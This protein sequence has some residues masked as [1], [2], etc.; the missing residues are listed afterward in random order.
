ME[1]QRRFVAGGTRRPQRGTGATEYP[2]LHAALQH[3]QT[4]DPPDAPETWQ[5]P[6]PDPRTV[7]R[8]AQAAR[9]ILL[10]RDTG[11][12]QSIA[13]IA[14]GAGVQLVQ[15]RETE[16]TRTHQRETVLVGH[17]CAGEAASLFPGARLV[18]AGFEE[19]QDVLWRAAARSPG[20]RVAVLPQASAWLGEYLGELGLNGGAARIT[21]LAGGCGGAGTSTLAALLAATHTLAG[22]RTLLID[23]D[24]VSTGLWPMLRPREPEGIGWEDL[25]HSRGALAPGQ[26]AEILPLAQGSAVLSWVRQPGSY[27]PEESLVVAVLAASRRIYEDIVIDA[28]RLPA[29]L[30]GV[31]AL[32][33][34]RLLVMP[35]RCAA[36]RR[37]PVAAGANWSVVFTGKLAAGT[38][39]R[40]LAHGLGLPLGGYLPWL[41]PL[42]RG[43][44]EGRLMGVLARTAL[45]RRI[46]ALGAPERAAL[47]QA[48]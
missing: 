15:Y 9:C 18:L 38:D 36:N 2:A 31:L 27:V 22:R 1:E 4:Q 10:T 48:A 30:P 34:E 7:D 5:E 8:E 29:V 24:R 37:F 47:G 23:A 21:L 16:R 28:G 14:V 11:L 6:R 43:A 41:K 13:L 3:A 42:E 39:T 12:A 32:C 19:H 45:R 35:T 33:G 46:T 17:D 26:L 20:A 25:E 44:A 40:A